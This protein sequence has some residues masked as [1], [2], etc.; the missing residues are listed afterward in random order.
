MSE[1]FETK[2]NGY[3]VIATLDDDYQVTRVV[4]KSEPKWIVTNP[5]GSDLDLAAFTEANDYLI[6]QVRREIE[7]ECRE[8]TEH[9]H[10]V[11]CAKEWNV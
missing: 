2:Y 3:P 8:Y 1:S 11:S 7:A 9:I 6:A 10:A 5:D 4:L